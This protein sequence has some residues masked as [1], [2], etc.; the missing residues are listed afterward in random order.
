M[1]GRDRKSPGA[2]RAGGLAY[3][4]ALLTVLSKVYGEDQ[5]PRLSSD[6]HM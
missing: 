4:V 5:D 3:V 6:D 1:G 2:F